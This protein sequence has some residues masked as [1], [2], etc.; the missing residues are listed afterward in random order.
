M[1]EA[2]DYIVKDAHEEA[3]LLQMQGEVMLQDTPKDL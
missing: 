2:Y 3:Y 1:G